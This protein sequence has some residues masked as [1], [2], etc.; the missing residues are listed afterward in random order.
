MRSDVNVGASTHNGGGVPHLWYM[1]RVAD[2][3]QSYVL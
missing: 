3:L 2:L 1:E